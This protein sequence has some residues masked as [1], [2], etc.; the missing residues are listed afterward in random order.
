LARTLRL[1]GRAKAPEFFEMDDSL[2]GDPGPGGHTM[3]T[4][5]HE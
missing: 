2:L 5:S 4:T 1:A 3:V